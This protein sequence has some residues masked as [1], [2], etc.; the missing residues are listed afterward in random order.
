MEQLG[1]FEDVI[2]TYKDKLIILKRRIAKIDNTRG[3]PR[4]NTQRS[5]G[6]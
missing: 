3:G 6:L 1:A 4:S 5:N 2:V